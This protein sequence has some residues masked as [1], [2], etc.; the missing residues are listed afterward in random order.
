MNPDFKDEREG[1]TL[2]MVVEMLH[3]GEDPNMCIP[4]MALNRESRRTILKTAKRLVG[5]L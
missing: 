1:V 5:K 3:R 2:R 4:F